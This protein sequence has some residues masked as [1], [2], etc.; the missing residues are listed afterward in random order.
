MRDAIASPPPAAP[1]SAPLH[2]AP[3][4]FGR[5]LVAPFVV[6][7]LVADFWARLRLWLALVLGL[8]PQKT[9]LWLRTF[10]PVLLFV[11]IMLLFV[12]L[13]AVIML[14]SLVGDRR[15]RDAGRRGHVATWTG[16]AIALIA[17]FVL[18]NFSWIA[19]YLYVRSQG[20][21]LNN[22]VFQISYALDYFAFQMYRLGYPPAPDIP[23]LESGF[24]IGLAA[25]YALSRWATGSLAR[26]LSRWL[27]VGALAGL[28]VG[29]VGSTQTLAFWLTY[30]IVYHPVSGP[31]CS[32]LGCTAAGRIALIVLPL[33][34][35][36]VGALVG[37]LLGGALR[38]VPAM[39]GRRSGSAPTVSGTAGV[40]GAAEDTGSTRE[41][42]PAA[43]ATA[44]TG[45]VRLR[46]LA[47]ALGLG[48]LYGLCWVGALA[49]GW[50]FVPRGPEPLAA[51]GTG[52]LLLAL[53]LLAIAVPAAR[54]ELGRRDFTGLAVVA[55][56]LGVLPACIVFLLPTAS[57]QVG[58]VL[59]YPPN[60]TPVL[61]LGVALGW[62]Y[63]AAGR[64]TSR[65]WRAGTR[66]ALCG[67]LGFGLVLVA[68]IVARLVQNSQ[69]PACVGRGC[70]LGDAFLQIELEAFALGAIASP[71]LALAAGPLGAWLRV[72]A[73]G[74][75][76]PGS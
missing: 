50:T 48:I 10:S 62:A 26:H 34:Q 68:V 40:A 15:L 12:A 18:G 76:N 63:S 25:A 58:V 22:L 61:S 9:A 72:R 43:M 46:G 64:A 27:V 4:S 49:L 56:C 29:I 44:R 59:I 71:I 20:G 67:G 52:V 2:A 57:L 17:L 5:S 47:A 7:V 45:T 32:G 51:V 30:I 41:N 23:A 55:I 38:I 31:G 53:P 35:Q 21:S 70:F 13:P 69:Q 33:A 24:A 66:T 36:V 11:A 42:A 39:M 1:H 65:W 75:A 73:S 16:L 6:G 60:V 3:Q 54:G 37:S 8:D 74:A 28:G 14:V 19:L